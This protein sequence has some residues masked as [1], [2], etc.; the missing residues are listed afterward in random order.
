MITAVGVVVPARDE[1]DLIEP[2][3]RAL[4]R[5]LWRLPARV[6]RAVCVV[7]DRCADDTAARARATFGGWATGR[8]VVTDR[9]RTIGEVR[10]LGVHAV[11]A[12]L[13]GH[14]ASEVL[15]LNTDADTQVAS[16]WA[17]EHLRRVE[18]GAHAVT[19]PAELAGPFPGSPHA[20]RRYH[21]VVSGGVNVYGAN[22][23]VRA[24]AFDTVGGFGVC[25]TGEDH[26][27]W[28]RLG[29]AG[30]RCRVE[31]AAVVRTSSRLDGRAPD[32]LAALLRTT[33][34]EEPVA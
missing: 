23:G 12:G 32:G 28:R 20:A 33:L 22:L 24:D 8:V 17:R 19:G 4:R 15:L 21:A 9:P 29:E 6:E 11:R 30:F 13:A 1:R 14:A 25:R 26:D 34:R 10:D 27:L 18:R 2:C 3:L 7:A 16:G 5:A 31:P